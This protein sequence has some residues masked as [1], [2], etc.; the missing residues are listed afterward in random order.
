[1]SRAEKISGLSLLELTQIGIYKIWFYNDVLKRVYIGS[2]IRNGKTNLEKGFLNRWNLHLS[3]L[4]NNHNCTPKLQNAFNK[5]GLENIRFEIVDALEQDKPTSYY[6]NIETEYIKKFNS[7]ENGWNININGK[8][9]KGTPMRKEVKDKIAAANRGV[10][11]GM[12]NKYGYLNPMSK[13]VYQYDL[14]GKFIKKWD[15][16]REIDRVL[17]IPYK[18]IS[19]CFKTKSNFCKGYLWY[20]SDQGIIVDKYVKRNP[21]KNLKKIQ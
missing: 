21:I 6:E 1:M 9:C 14:D 13:P 15:C 10:N 19:Q 4:I 7:V 17:N 5:Y 8:N 20:N 12:Y 2:A 18:Q 16:A 11:N 3:N